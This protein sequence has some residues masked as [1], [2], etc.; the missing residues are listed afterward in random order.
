MADLIQWLPT[1][2]WAAHKGGVE[3]IE[4]SS[5]LAPVFALSDRLPIADNPFCPCDCVAFHCCDHLDRIYSK[6]LQLQPR[7]FGHRHKGKGKQEG[8]GK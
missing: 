4:G 5:A 1:D 8:Q 6:A 7:W 3:R 2:R